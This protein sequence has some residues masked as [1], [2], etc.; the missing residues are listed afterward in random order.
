[1]CTS[2][3]TSVLHTNALHLQ[4][5]STDLISRLYMASSVPQVSLGGA[6]APLCPLTYTEP[7]A[8]QAWVFPVAHEASAHFLEPYSTL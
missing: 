1:M 5:E 4:C 3:C 6:I 8:N 2:T 7:A